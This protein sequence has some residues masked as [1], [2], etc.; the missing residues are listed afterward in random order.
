VTVLRASKLDSL[1]EATILG[2]HHFA[3]PAMGILA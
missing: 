3:E 1:Q 2:S